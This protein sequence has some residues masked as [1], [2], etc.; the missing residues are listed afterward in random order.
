MVISGP[1][2]VLYFQTS[3]TKKKTKGKEGR[4]EYG[5]L[6]KKDLISPRLSSVLANRNNGI[7]MPG[8]KSCV[9]KSMGR[10]GGNR[11]EQK[12]R[13]KKEGEKRKARNESGKRGGGERGRRAQVLIP[14]EL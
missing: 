7:S 12:R 4:G 1:L 8:G 10:K 14:A 2:F 6:K 9:L 11:D 3:K 13:G 5:F